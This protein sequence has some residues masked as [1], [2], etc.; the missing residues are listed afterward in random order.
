MPGAD[1]VQADRC[2]DKGRIVGNK[3]ADSDARL[4]QQERT[5]FLA[6]SFK[7]NLT[8]SNWSGDNPSRTT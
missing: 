7:C 6:C 8:S 2:V 4:I 1:I 3:Q 5:A